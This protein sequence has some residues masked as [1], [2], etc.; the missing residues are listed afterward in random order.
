VLHFLR[1][2]AHSPVRTQLLAQLLTCDF[3]LCKDLVNGVVSW[4]VIKFH[5]QVGIRVLLFIH[6][7]ILQHL[8]QQC[9]THTAF[10]TNDEDFGTNRFLLNGTKGL[11]HFVLAMFQYYQ[12]ECIKEW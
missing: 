6:A 1:N 11:L 10:S 4:P 8:V 2:G 9:F 7:E 3:C 12:I 5:N